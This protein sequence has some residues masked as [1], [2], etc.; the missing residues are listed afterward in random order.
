MGYLALLRLPGFLEQSGRQP[1]GTL[2]TFLAEAWQYSQL[3]KKALDSVPETA[4]LTQTFDKLFNRLLDRME[5]TSPDFSQICQW[6]KTPP[7]DLLETQSVQSMYPLMEVAIKNNWIAVLYDPATQGLIS[8]CLTFWGANGQHELVEKTVISLSQGLTGD[9]IERQLALTHLMDARP[10]VRH[11][12]LLDEIFGKLNL[13][14]ANETKSGALQFALLLAWDLME[15]S[16]ENNRETQVMNLMATLHFHA[17]EDSSPFMER[18]HIA[19]HWLF[20]RSTP[21]VIRRLVH[22]A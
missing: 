2:L 17:D 8:D 9:S 20:E 10:W 22:C 19:R 1:E 3:Q 7:G 5:K 13:L 6:F 12:Q 16:L 21:E 4:G 15:P 11:P 18:S 14:L